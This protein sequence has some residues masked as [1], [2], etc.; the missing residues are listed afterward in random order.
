MLNLALLSLL[1]ASSVHA[2]PLNICEELAW[3]KT[4]IDITKQVHLETLAKYLK[5]DAV[6]N[7]HAMIDLYPG[8]RKGK[9][10]KEIR[11][12][13]KSV[14]AELIVLHRDNESKI[15]D[16]TSEL[17][18]TVCV[19]VSEAGVTRAPE[20]SVMRRVCRGF[21]RIQMSQDIHGPFISHQFM[22][23]TNKM[24]ERER[25]KE[26]WQKLGADLKEIY[27]D[28]EKDFDELDDVIDSALAD[29]RDFYPDLCKDSFKL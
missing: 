2:D 1:I 3:L 15:D 23:W 5:S 17:L 20:V 10:S 18:K 14:I 9:E 21:R 27:L 6:E 7:C 24:E 22:F 13:C 25:E 16:I 4:S 29:K 11:K 8:K 12:E 26:D 19:S 28:Y